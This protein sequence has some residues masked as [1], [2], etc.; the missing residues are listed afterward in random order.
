MG[1]EPDMKLTSEMVTL[2]GGDEN[3]KPFKWFVDL[4]VKAYLSVRPYQE[5]IVS[6]VSLMLGTGLPC[7]RGQ[8]IKLLRQRFA[9][10]L[11]EKQAAGRVQVHF[12]TI[13]DY[14][15]YQIKI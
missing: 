13:Y 11:T 8:T 9:P 6:L 5:S 7:F 4:C 14:Q 1:W 15:N 3:S 12:T 10:T 2:M